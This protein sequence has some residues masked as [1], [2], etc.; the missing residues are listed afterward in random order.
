MRSQSPKVEMIDGLFKPGSDNNDSG[1]V[2]YNLFQGM[3]YSK[4]LGFSVIIL[5]QPPILI[6]MAFVAG[7]CCWTS[8]QV[9][10]SKNPVKL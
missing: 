5:F 9:R 8:I 10:G 7:S 4:V 3:T 1:I 6:Y 2:R